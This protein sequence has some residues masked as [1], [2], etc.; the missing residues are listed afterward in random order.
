M[1]TVLRTATCLVAILAA[2]SI[3]MAVCE[4]QGLA[5]HEGK[6]SKW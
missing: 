5:L 6:E 2:D 4:R 1:A 3:M